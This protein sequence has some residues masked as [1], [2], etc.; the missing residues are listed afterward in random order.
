MHLREQL[1]NVRGKS[2]S[3]VRRELRKWIGPI[4]KSKSPEDDIDDKEQMRQTL[5]QQDLELRKAR[6]MN[7][8]SRDEIRKLQGGN[9]TMMSSGVTVANRLPIRV[10]DD[11]AYQQIPLKA[12]QQALQSAHASTRRSYKSSRSATRQ[13]T[14]SH[15]SSASSSQPVEG[16]EDDNDHQLRW[17]RTRIRSRDGRKSS[18]S[19]R[20][21]SAEVLMDLRQQLQEVRGKS[22]SPEDDID[23]KE[24]M[25]QS[26]SQ[27]DLELKKAMEMIRRLQDEIRRKQGGN[28]TMMSSVVTDAN[29]S[30]IRMDDA[31]DREI[32]SQQDLELRKARETIR[33]L[34]DENRKK[35]GGNLSMMNS[36]VN[37]PIRVDDDPACRQI[38]LKA[39]RHA[40]EIQLKQ[41]NEEYRAL[42]TLL[43]DLKQQKATHVSESEEAIQAVTAQM[44]SARAAIHEMRD[45]LSNLSRQANDRQ[46]LNVDVD[47]QSREMEQLRAQNRRLTAQNVY[48][49]KPFITAYNESYFSRHSGVATAELNQFKE[50]LNIGHGSSQDNPG[51]SPK[52]YQ[53]CSSKGCSPKNYKR[54]L[55]HH[56]NLQKQYEQSLM[57]L[58]LHQA[59][60]GFKL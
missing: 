5:S 6:E 47:H 56:Q 42:Q 44:D 37:V 55:D 22:K 24:Q 35:Q 23:D 51:C 19:S 2:K 50:T 21:M 29:R 46:N 25:R 12:S 58:K 14:S 17:S 27:Q 26:L 52:N 36:G 60:C 1:R 53:G 20:R 11:P 13:F 57:N 43:D 28:P 30:P 3:P 38:P 48:E 34:Q 9:P 18:E 16:P 39:S 33:R 41:R 31:A 4:G 32:L 15:A 10:D 7:R 8:R 40:L 45:K 59:K 54:L 49:A